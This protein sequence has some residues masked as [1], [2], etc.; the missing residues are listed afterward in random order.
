MADDEVL[1]DDEPDPVE[2]D[3][4]LS[5]GAVVGVEPLAPVV[6]AL[7]AGPPVV[8]DEPAALAPGPVPAPGPAAGRLFEA[9]VDGAGEPPPEERT[10]PTTNATTARPPTIAALGHVARL[11]KRN[12]W[13]PPPNPQP[14]V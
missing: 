1:A 3:E 11:D 13:H 2:G 4:W 14:V 9:R 8:G 6:G 7:A 5:A 10:S 12:G